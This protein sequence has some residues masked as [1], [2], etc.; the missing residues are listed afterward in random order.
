MLSIQFLREMKQFPIYIVFFSILISILVSCTD[1]VTYADSVADENSLIADYIKRKNIK[2][3]STFPADKAIWNQ[4]EYVLT[5]SGLYFHLEKVGG[6]VVDTSTIKRFD[7]VGT[8]YEAYTLTAIPDTTV[9]N[10]STSAF[11]NPPAFVFGSGS[12]T[13][14]CA[15]FNEAASYM[16]R[17]DS[18]ARLIVPSKIGFSADVQAVK[19]MCYLLRIKFQR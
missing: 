14:V 18:E 16:K 6:T 11:P 3:I 15:A 12:Y 5:A 10:L 13:N 1:T 8:R 9:S 17:N 19:P 7:L 2:V 4:N